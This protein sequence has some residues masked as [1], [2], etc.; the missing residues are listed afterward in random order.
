MS[1][2]SVVDALSVPK[3]P[4]SG[5]PNAAPKRKRAADYDEDRRREIRETNRI[6]AR[7]CRAR[8]KHLMIELEKTVA[9]LTAEH[10]ALTKQNRE[11]T[12]RLET[13]ERTAAVGL[14]PAVPGAGANFMAAQA[15]AAAGQAGGGMARLGGQAGASATMAA[16]MGSMNG[17]AGF[18]GLNPLAALAGANFS[19]LSGGG[20]GGPY[21]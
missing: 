14:G 10:S 19:A 1:S 21:Q 16:A 15:A 6:A 4:S 3:R 13:L 9:N 5:G 18:G 12:I 8:K 2:P 11:L 7:E 20:A 17:A